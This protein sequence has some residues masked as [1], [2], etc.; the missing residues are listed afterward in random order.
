VAPRGRVAGLGSLTRPLRTH[1]AQKLDSDQLVDFVIE[2]HKRLGEGKALVD[3]VASLGMTVEAADVVVSTVRDAYC[4]TILYSAGAQP[5]NFHGDYET[6]PIFQAALKRFL[7]SSKG[8]APLPTSAPA[9]K[10]KPWWRF[11]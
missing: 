4:R 10:R 3:A 6:D 5:Q 7:A 2:T 9:Q 11:W 8:G 1:M